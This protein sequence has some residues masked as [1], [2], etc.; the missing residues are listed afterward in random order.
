[1]VSVSFLLERLIGAFVYCSV[2][3][4]FYYSLKRK[5]SFRQISKGLFKFVI[6]LSIM[7]YFYVPS[8]QADLYRLNAIGDIWVQM[9]FKEFSSQILLTSTTP[10]AYLLIY[11]CR[12]SKLDGLLPALSAFVFYS[13]V[14]HI[15]TKTCKNEKFFS[16]HKIAI[17]VFFTMCSGTFLSVISGIRSTMAFSIIARCYFDEIFDNKGFMS[18]IPFYV[19]A[20]LIHTAAIPM[21]LLRIFTMAFSKSNNFILKLFQLLLLPVGAL[22]IYY[23]GSKYIDAAIDKYIVYS[24][25]ET[26]SNMKVYISSIIR[27][28]YFSFIAIKYVR[29]NKKTLDNSDY[30]IYLV[31]LVIIE[32]GLI[33]NFVMFTRFLMYMS[34]LIIPALY[35]YLSLGYATNEFIVNPKRYNS[36]FLI[37]ILFLFLSY[38][39]GD[40]SAY[41]F[42]VLWR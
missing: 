13:N 37:S 30:R 21:F 5:N 38:L 6:I 26:Y 42:F 40:L 41:K 36:L 19:I 10:V 8:K 3:I 2:V 22:A 12:L 31:F 9:G 33:G 1:M 18:R 4:F 39:M 34:I 14:F 27:L 23:F 35:N 32:F 25:T 16:S 24:T 20:C 7:A 15:I 29:F 11:L 17:L 28:L